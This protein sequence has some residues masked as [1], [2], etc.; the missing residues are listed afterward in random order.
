MDE[1]LIKALDKADMAVGDLIVARN[2]GAGGT[3]GYLNPMQSDRF[4][5]DITDLP[6]IL[7]K[8][9]FEP[10]SSPQMEINKIGIGSRLLRGA[11]ADGVALLANQRTK[12]TTSQVLLTTKELIG[13]VH[14]P[15][16]VLEDNIERGT[17]ETTIMNLIS[18]RASIDLQELVVLGD[19][20]NTGDELLK[21]TDGVIKLATSHIIDFS[22]TTGEI[23]LAAFK[24][25]LRGMPNKYLTNRAS[26]NFFVSPAVEVEY[27]STL[28]QRATQL[29]DSRVQEWIPNSPFGI[30]IFPVSHIPND[31]YILC[32]PKNIILGV[33]RDI[34]I[35]TDRDIRAR[36]LIIVV[37]LRVDIQLE[38]ADAIVKAIGLNPDLDTITTT[39]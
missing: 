30:K 5:R 21:V 4:L 7:N 27:A 13:E 10:M 39:T 12:P 33:Q 20:A 19:T 11:P 37:T 34:M 29:G 3:G 14:I 15:Y 17:L 25:G 31:K 36:T 9:R 18:T 8:I 16:K 6:T 22:D 24:H 35:E 1:K 23:N 32:N 2:G 26:Y 28:A 38:E